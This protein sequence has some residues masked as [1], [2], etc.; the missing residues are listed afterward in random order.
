MSKLSKDDVGALLRGGVSPGL[1]ASLAG[2]VARFTGGIPA[3]D[4]AAAEEPDAAS[5]AEVR[6]GYTTTCRVWGRLSRCSFKH[7]GGRKYK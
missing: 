5:S 4:C 6:H 7:E 2:H 3:A 1:R